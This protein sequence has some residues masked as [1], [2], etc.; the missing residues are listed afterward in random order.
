MVV[1][2]PPSAG[3]SPNAL[4]RAGRALAWLAGVA[5]MLCALA[6]LLAGPAYR[7]GALTLGPA[8]QTVRWGATVALGAAA[9]A[10]AALLLSL[11]GHAPAPARRWAALALVL[12]LVV[13]A[14]PLVMYWRLQSLPKIHDITTDFDNPPAFE[15]VLP[16]RRGARNPVD[17]AAATGVEQRKGYPDIAPLT[18]PLAP[19]LAFARALEVAHAMGWEIVASQ[20]D[21]RIEA[22]DTT[23]LFGFKD[24]VV[25]RIASHGSGSVV[26][27]RSLS[28]VGGS[29]FGT[30]AHRVRSF[31]KRLAESANVAP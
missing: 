9:V 10:L 17:Y 29:D 2:T 22:T 24:D 5:A 14:P 13:A 3:P 26:D 12:S 19:P 30:N 1:T 8:L 6:E 23:L 28:R 7:I 4:G 15:A 11:A 18:L 25:V 20:P 31:L 21:A 27:V 16:L